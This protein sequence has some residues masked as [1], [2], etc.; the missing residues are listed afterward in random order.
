NDPL[1]NGEIQ[2]ISQAIA[3]QSRG[4]TFATAR[5]ASGTAG[6]GRGAEKDSPIHVVVDE[7]VSGV[8][9]KWVKF[10]FYFG[11]TTY[12]L[13]VFLTL[14]I[15]ATGP[16]RKAAGTQSNEAQASQQTARFT[17]VHGCDEAKEDL[18]ELVEF[19]KDP[20]QF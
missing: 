4:G 12:F 13:L 11:I 18:Q 5:G 9:F 7:S 20:S 16:M 15:E 10:L 8:V 19:L 6:Y 14:A 1:T 2:A 17:D 3:A